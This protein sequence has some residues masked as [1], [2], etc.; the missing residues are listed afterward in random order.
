MNGKNRP[1]KQWFVGNGLLQEL[2]SA[3]KDSVLK[4]REYSQHLSGGVT[5]NCPFL[6]LWSKNSS[7]ER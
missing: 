6:M 2:S 1:D 7:Q 5:M 3:E 4:Y